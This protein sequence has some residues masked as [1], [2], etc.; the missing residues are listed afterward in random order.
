MTAT[1][2]MITPNN[3]RQTILLYYMYSDI[4]TAPHIVMIFM[5]YHLYKPCSGIMIHQ[6]NSDIPK[7]SQTQKNPST[8]VSVIPN[9]NGLHFTRRQLHQMMGQQHLLERQRIPRIL[10]FCMLC[11]CGVTVTP[12]HTWKCCCS[13]IAWWQLHHNQWHLY[14]TTS[15]TII[16]RPSSVT[17]Y[18]KYSHELY[19]MHHECLGWAESVTAMS[20]YFASLSSWGTTILEHMHECSKNINPLS[21]R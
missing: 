3:R 6:Q 13:K 20:L 2:T 9:H 19:A 8:D 16:Q 4:H 5:L 21:A 18:T 14:S 10:P 1:H 17:C 11:K 12:M 15:K 7:Q